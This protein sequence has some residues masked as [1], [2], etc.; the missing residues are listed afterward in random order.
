VTQIALGTLVNSDE[1]VLRDISH[2]NE[3]HDVF[4]GAFAISRLP[5]ECCRDKENPTPNLTF[6]GNPKFATYSRY[7]SLILESMNYLI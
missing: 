5:K 1:T 6:I 7:W 2:T 4:G 3:V